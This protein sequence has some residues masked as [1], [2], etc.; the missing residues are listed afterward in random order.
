[1]RFTCFLALLVVTFITCN[2]GLTVA[3]EISV[4]NKVFPAAN[5]ELFAENT[6][7]RLRVARNVETEERVAIVP[8]AAYINMNRNSRTTTQILHKVQEHKPLRKWEAAI[9]VFLGIGLVAGTI[10]GSIKVA[11][12][13]SS[14]LYN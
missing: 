11:N 13:A 6:V 1:M 2:F 4:R 8:V 9:L 3:N 14:K 12:L 5:P 10:Y 7:R